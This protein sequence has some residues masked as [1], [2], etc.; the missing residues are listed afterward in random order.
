AKLEYLYY[1][2]GNVAGTFPS[3]KGYKSSLD[4][5][6]VRVGLNRQLDWGNPGSVGSWTGDSALL[7]SG[8][9]NTHGQVPFI[10]PGYGKFHSPYFGDNSLFGGGQYKNT[11]SATAFVGMRPWA[12]TEIY[13]NPELM[14]GNGLSDTFGL[15]GF[16]NGEAQKSGFPIPRMNIGRIF[17]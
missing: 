2:F 7:A 10:A 3:G 1:S 14:Q 4:L 13:V 6:T 16:P 12:G 5:Q 11:T 17:V 15:G 9:W 8:N